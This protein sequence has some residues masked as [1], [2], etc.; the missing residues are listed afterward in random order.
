MD[1]CT[2]TQSFFWHANPGSMLNFVGGKSYKVLGDLLAMVGLLL[3]MTSINI[4]TAFGQDV[5]KIALGSYTQEMKTDIAMPIGADSNVIKLF[6]ANDRIKAVTTNGIYVYQQG[7]WHHGES[8]SGYQTAVM[9]LHGRLWLAGAEF[10]VKEGGVQRIAL[11]DVIRNI[12]VTTLYWETDMILHVGTTNGLYSYD[13]D[14]SLTPETEGKRINAIVLD[15]HQRLWIATNGGLLRRTHLDWQNLDDMLMASGTKGVYLSLAN[16]DPADEVLFGGLLSIGCIAEDGNHWMHS[17]ADGLPFGPITT[18]R[19]HKGVLW[20]GTDFGAIKKDQEW[21]YYLGKR[22][23]PHNRIND[24]LVIDD[25]TVWL[26]TPRGISQIEEV[27]LTLAEKAEEYE[28]II[29]LRHNRRGLINNS[30]LTIPG[31][32]ASNK[33][34]NEDNDGL[35]TSTYLA[36]ECFRY[37]VT[38]SPLAKEYAIRT[39]EAL[40]RLETVT[41][42]SGLPARSYALAT[43]HVE[44]SRSPHA[45]KWRPSPDGKWQ[46]LDDTSSDEI[47]GH[48]FAISLFYD[49][50]A[51]GA[52]K[53][54]VKALIERIMNHIIDHDFHLIDYDGKPTRWGVWHP[55]SINHANNWAYEKGLYSLEILASLKAALAITGNPKFERTYQHLIEN[56]HYAENAIQAKIHGPFE[57]SHSDD[58]LMYF[59]YYT[60]YRY[61]REDQYWPL[62]QKSIERS[63]PISRP[64]RMPVWNIICSVVLGRDCDLETALA[65]LQDYP[66]DLINWTMKNSHRWDLQEDPMVG[67]GGVRQAVYPIPTPESG[68]SRWNTNPR[69]FDTGAGGLKEESPT[70]FL[71]PYWMAR[72]HGLWME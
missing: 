62:Y 7:S 23:L 21:H 42:I 50:V 2:K 13:G 17:G 11:P 54:R 64:E 46:W 30:H 31:D 24:I 10:I 52:I 18:I 44:Q 68:I 72:Y 69:E 70:Y 4:R 35:W 3:F 14:W 16:P 25:K 57:N 63:W 39:Y 40:E 43:D 58:I 37:A 61:A 28:Q 5:A 48:I 60:L 55:D 19:S 53:A 65:E 9:D 15:G 47:V 32:L 22:W 66:M 36:A 34:V 29:N 27:D 45:K 12:S 6:K 56:H 67:R 51:D 1:S 33:M 41:G 20:L 26:A 71:L 38:K 49:L 59:P 8:G